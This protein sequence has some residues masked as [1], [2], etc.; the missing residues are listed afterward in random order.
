MAPDSQGM[1]D[2]VCSLSG[3]KEAINRAKEMIMNIVNQRGRNEGME[4]GGGSLDG[5]PPGM[6]HHFQGYTSFTFLGSHCM[7]S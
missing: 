4:G 2:R 6:K 7:K 1:S 3:T 5:A